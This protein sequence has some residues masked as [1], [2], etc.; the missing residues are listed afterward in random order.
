MSGAPLATIMIVIAAVAGLS[1]MLGLVL[2]AANRPYFRHP[3]PDSLPGKV[4]GGIHQGDPRSQGPPEWERADVRA[5]PSGDRAAAEAD[6]RR[7]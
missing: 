2:L 6:Q 7:S 4:R 3:H 1:I 5:E